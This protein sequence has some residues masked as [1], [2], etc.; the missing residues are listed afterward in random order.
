MCRSDA[1]VFVMQERQMRRE[2]VS[3]SP[4]QKGR[5]C[6]ATSRLSPQ[7]MTADVAF[8][9]LSFDC[10]RILNAPH[11]AVGQSRPGEQTHM[12]C[13]AGIL[14]LVGKA[15]KRNEMT[16]CVSP[17]QTAFL[18]LAR[19]RRLSSVRDEC[20]EARVL[21]RS[22]P[23]SALFAF[24]PLAPHFSNLVA[25]SSPLARYSRSNPAWQRTC[26]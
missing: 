13:R 1:Y 10:P 9:I 2:S 25:I 22:L 21:R 8:E 12:L 16:R 11:L 5:V 4:H 6:L 26:C 7:H 15:W 19:L 20:P 3:L 14:P 17:E 24:F 23:R 18:D